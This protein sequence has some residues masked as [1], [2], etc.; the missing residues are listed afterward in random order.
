MCLV[1]SFFDATAHLFQ[2]IY[3]TVV[4]EA[5]LKPV[6]VIINKVSERVVHKSVDKI[7]CSVHMPNDE[8]IAITRETEDDRQ[9]ASKNHDQILSQ[10]QI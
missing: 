6:Q 7:R 8:F 4:I 2:C 9:R 1:C 10:V 3:S 5:H